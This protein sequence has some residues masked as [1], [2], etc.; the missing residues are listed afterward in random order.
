[1]TYEL[2]TNINC[3]ELTVSPKVG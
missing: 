2:G 1:V 3:E